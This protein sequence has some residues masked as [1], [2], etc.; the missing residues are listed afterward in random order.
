[1]GEQE[2]VERAGLLAPA[3]LRGADTQR[4][5][6]RETVARTATPG[7]SDTCSLNQSTTSG[8]APG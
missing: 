1:M 3:D 8:R 7:A 5:P 2:K 4:A 6:A